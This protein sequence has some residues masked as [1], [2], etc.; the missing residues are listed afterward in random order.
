MPPA[1]P[2]ER[3][4]GDEA[5]VHTDRANARPSH[6]WIPP[7]TRAQNAECGAKWYWSVF[8]GVATG[9]MLFNVGALLIKAGPSGSCGRSW[10]EAVYAILKPYR[11]GRVR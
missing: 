7:L 10:H 9:E 6:P 4:E 8:L 2:T 1:K 11:M 3:R 5:H